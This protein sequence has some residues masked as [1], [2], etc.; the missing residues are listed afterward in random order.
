MSGLP[1]SR[2]EFLKGGQA[3]HPDLDRL[4]PNWPTKRAAKRI[5][6]YLEKKPPIYH[7]PKVDEIPP[8][9]PVTHS[10]KSLLVGHEI[11]E[12][13]DALIRE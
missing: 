11:F 7:P 5:R 13:L 1:L 2:R 8:I 12:T 10:T 3:S 6:T 4:N 9:L